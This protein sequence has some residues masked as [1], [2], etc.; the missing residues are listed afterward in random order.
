MDPVQKK[1]KEAL[2]WVNKEKKG[3]ERQLKSDIFSKMNGSKNNM[4]S[5]YEYIKNIKNQLKLEKQRA[6]T[7]ARREAYNNAKKE[8]NLENMYRILMTLVLFCSRKF[9]P[10]LLVTK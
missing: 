7:M 8:A 4:K 10:Q 6:I 3:K 9:G 5:I 2:N 1:K